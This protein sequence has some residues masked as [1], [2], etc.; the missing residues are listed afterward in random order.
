MTDFKNLSILLV[1][2]EF[3]IALDAEQMLRALGVTQVEIAA[4][5]EQAEKRSEAG[6]FD[7]V[8][9]D[10]N[11][12]GKLSVPIARAFKERG[13]PVVFA[14]GYELRSRPLS[15]VD[16]GIIV[17]KPYTA[18]RFREALSA[19]LGTHNAAE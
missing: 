14:S 13:I 5:F 11:L 17:T 18:D 10:L 16:G 9:L 19:A 6:R 4:T 12:N 2:D 8:V 1:E 3:L 7:L 15:G